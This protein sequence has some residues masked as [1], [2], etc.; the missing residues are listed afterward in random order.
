MTRFRA[1]KENRA[2]RP[3][4]GGFTTDEPILDQSTRRPRLELIEEVLA[5]DE[6]Q[7]D[8]DNFNLN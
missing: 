8:T 1:G 5:T 6:T 4:S 2:A 7:I 3:C